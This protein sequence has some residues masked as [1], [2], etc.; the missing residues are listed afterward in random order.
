MG[1]AV[2]SQHAPSLAAPDDRLESWKEIAAY[3]KRDVSTVQRWEKRDGLPVHRLPHDKLGSVFAFK[4]EL[5]AWWN[6]GN[7]RL[8]QTDT[9]PRWQLPKS[10]RRVA[11]ASVALLAAAA[12]GGAVVWLTRMPPA[13]AQPVTRSVVTLPPDKA[14]FS[15]SGT[16]SLAISPEGRHIVYAAFSDPLASQLYLRALDEFEGRPIPGTEGASAPF[17]SPDGKW[18]GFFAGGELKKVAISGGAPVVIAK[19]PNHRGGSWGSDDSIVFAPDYA[20]GLARVAAAGGT[21]VFLTRPDYASREKTH[22]FPE[23]LPGG[24]GVIFTTGTADIESFDDARIEVLVVGTGERR[25]LLSGATNARYVM[26]GHLLYAHAAAL[27]AVPFDLARLAVVGSP[28]RVLEGIP[29]D[30]AAGHAH[31]AVS[32]NGTLV[33]G[34]GGAWTQSS[35]LVLADRAGR[36]RTLVEHTGLV[37]PRLSPDGQRI[38]VGVSG[39]TQ[40]VWIVESSRGTLTRLTTGWDNETPVWTVDGQRVIYFSNREGAG[41]LYSQNADGGGPAEQLT[42]GPGADPAWSPDGAVLA[43][44]RSDAATGTDIWT[45]RPADGWK[46]EPLVREPFDQRHAAFSPDGRWLAY[47]SNETGKFEVY[48]R[49][50]PDL[51]AKWRVSIDGGRNPVWSRDG[52]ELFYREESQFFAVSVRATP[53]HAGKPALLFDAPFARAGRFDV[54]AE[55]QFLLVAEDNDPPRD[56]GVVQNW[57]EELASRLDIPFRSK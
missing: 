9:A 13:P 43:V 40:Q 53:F 34:R 56:I 26:T 48:V 57:V 20:D 24:K 42:K 35:R 28:S 5:D 51:G 49:P 12:M 31:F 29:G 44:L 47:M 55:G 8:D 38:A 4:A 36:S 7:E 21:P 16:P 18:V 37:A 45:L 22:R 52:R 3:L 30:S 25:V 27:Y 2:R 23:V 11:G 39:A 6:R 32:H 1:D 41:H 10:W 54:T 17:F 46:P 33:S 14:L 15:G 50:Y 19:A